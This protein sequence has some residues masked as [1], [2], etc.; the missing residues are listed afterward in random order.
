MA[1]GVWLSLTKRAGTSSRFKSVHYHAQCKKWNVQ[2]KKR[3]LGLFSEE[4]DA[5]TAYNFH[6][7]E[8]YG[9]FARYNFP[10]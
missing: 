8:E 5:A 9:E 1:I 4:A 7:R 10:C 6:A 3:H 2:I